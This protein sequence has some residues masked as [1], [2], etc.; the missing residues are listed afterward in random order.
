MICSAIIDQVLTH[1]SVRGS[2][3]ALS[4]FCALGLRDGCTGKVYQQIQHDF[5]S[6]IYFKR[7]TRMMSLDKRNLNPSAMGFHCLF[8]KQIMANYSSSPTGFS[9]QFYI[10]FNLARI[11]NSS[12]EDANI[13]AAVQSPSDNTLGVL[14][15]FLQTT[16]KSL[17][18]NALCGCCSN[19]IVAVWT[20]V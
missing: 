14:V 2:S 1:Q 16:L 12:W 4:N 20:C 6:G 7:W 10:R 5:P 17:S 9:R 18:E 8:K 3:S 13:S 11:S 19:L 15:R